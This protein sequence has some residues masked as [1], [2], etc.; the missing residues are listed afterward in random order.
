MVYYCDALNC[1]YELFRIDPPAPSAQLVYFH[2]LHQNYCLGNPG[3]VQIT[4]RE[5]SLR[6]RLSKQSITEAK[7]I[8]KNRG[9]IDFKTN[10]DKPHKATTYTLNF[11]S[12]MVGQQVGQR[13][14]Q[15]LGQALG[16]SP[17]FD[18]P[19]REKT[20][21]QYADEDEAADAPPSTPALPPA[22]PIPPTPSPS[23]LPSFIHPPTPQT[24]TPQLTDADANARALPLKSPSFDQDDL[25]ALVEY[26]QRQKCGGLLSF[27]H[28]SKLAVYLQ[29]KGKEWV[30]AMM[31]TASDK[32][33]NR[34]GLSP[35][36]LFGVIETELKEKTKK[37]DE[38]SGGYHYEKP[39]NTI[40]FDEP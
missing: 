28:Q 23:F 16:Q 36:F 25:D 22:P 40:D 35:K 33:G 1:A 14:G 31:D 9:L 6:T 30:M 18:S 20:R 4:D 17:R 39:V 27:E 15:T 26:W 29:K 8:L 3:T 5:L 32:N 2:L 13:V 12:E 7:R 19:I 37:E 38:K 11:F 21:G 24:G 10:R 34:Y